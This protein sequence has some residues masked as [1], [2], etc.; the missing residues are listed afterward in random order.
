MQSF[1][2]QSF[3]QGVQMTVS[4]A[5]SNIWLSPVVSFSSHDVILNAGGTVS[6]FGNNQHGQCNVPD[7]LSDVI[8]VARGSSH[9]SAL[10]SDGTVVCWGDNRQSQLDIP[11][12][13]KNVV[14][15]SVGLFHTVALCS[16]GSVFSW[17]NENLKY[18]NRH[19]KAFDPRDSTVKDLCANVADIATGDF[20]TVL[21]YKDK[22]VSFFGDTADD[23]CEISDLNSTGIVK[24][25]AFYSRTVLLMSNGR[26]VV[27]GIQ[28]SLPSL[29]DVV[30][31]A[32]QD[33]GSSQILNKSLSENTP[34]FQGISMPKTS[35]FLFAQHRGGNVSFL[36]LSRVFPNEVIK[37]GKYW[38]GSHG[39]QLIPFEMT[40]RNWLKFILE[41][42]NVRGLLKLVPTRIKKLPE[43]KTTRVLSQL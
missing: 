28:A 2:K 18:T 41:Y 30:D 31:I 12:T 22:T 19:F 11:D 13:L 42:G 34:V 37:N 6:C 40:D 9:C 5:S 29:V 38:K 32:I 39:I 15:I 27:N 16:D 17:G 35:G 23:Q 7:S 25:I 36:S 26:V 24:I 43:Y 20:H 4:R 1:C 33:L 3:V 21:L 8:Y 10:K 14:K